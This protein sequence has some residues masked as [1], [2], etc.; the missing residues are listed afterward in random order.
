MTE[1]YVK[2]KENRTNEWPKNFIVYLLKKWIET[3]DSD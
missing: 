1:V 2:L 3:T